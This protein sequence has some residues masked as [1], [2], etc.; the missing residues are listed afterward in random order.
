M[1]RILGMGNVLVDVL[2]QVNDD[3]LLQELDL[4]KGSMQLLSPR[5][6]ISQ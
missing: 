5:S 4:P 3:T 1:K 2:V 6:V